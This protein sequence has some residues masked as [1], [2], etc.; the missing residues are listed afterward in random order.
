MVK[1]I[2]FGA[3]VVALCACWTSAGAQNVYR[4]GDS[5]SNQPCAGATM[6]LA[7][8]SR[9]AA[10]RAATEAATGRAAKL[11]ALMQKE[12]VKQEGE[13]AQA[14]IPPPRIEAPEPLAERP[15]ARRKSKPRKSELFTAV[16]PRKPGDTA[17]KKSKGRKPSKRA[18]A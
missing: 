7:D 3:V 13:P 6:V 15:V 4:C 12:R 11:A 17:A 5:Y 9:S 14:T 10:Q 8:D 16:A 1:P 18:A 2:R